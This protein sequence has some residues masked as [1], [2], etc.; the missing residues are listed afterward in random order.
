ML[1]NMA[2]TWYNKCKYNLHIMR[3]NT[4]LEKL[5]FSKNEASAYRTLLL[6]GPQTLAELARASGVNRPALYELLPRLLKQGL[7]HTSLRG[8][9]TLYAA[10]D[11]EVLLSVAAALQ[12]QVASEI[13]HLHEVYK[14]SERVTVR[15][16]EGVEGIQRVFADI[17]QSLPRE[18]VFYRYSSGRERNVKN[19]KFLPEGYRTLR[20]QKKLERFVISSPEYHK[21]PHKPRMERMVRVVPER[22]SLFDLNV[23]QIV[24]GSKVAIINYDQES[25][26]IIDDKTLAQFQ[27]R[28]FKLL[29]SLL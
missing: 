17:V 28:L 2:C 13:P 12:Q 7:V 16:L 22:F 20:D 6:G 11:P 29:F 21:H 9:R 15:H 27:Q 25:A 26:I 19:A 10:G 1:Q 18:G 3:T 14:R 23:S 8:K 24:Y 4:I 5:G